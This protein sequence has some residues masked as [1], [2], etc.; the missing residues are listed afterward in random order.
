MEADKE[1]DEA[2]KFLHG[3]YGETALSKILSEIKEGFDEKNKPK[4]D[5]YIK[6]KVL[7]LV[8]DIKKLR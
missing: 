1:L 8:S 4:S 2:I 6:E 3:I 5:K 7:S